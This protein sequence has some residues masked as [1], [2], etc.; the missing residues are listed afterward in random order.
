MNAP[1]NNPDANKPDNAPAAPAGFDPNNPPVTSLPLPDEAEESAEDALKDDVGI[2]AEQNELIEEANAKLRQDFANELQESGIETMNAKALAADPEK[3]A[4]NLIK[5]YGDYQKIKAQ[6]TAL[7]NERKSLLP[8]ATRVDAV[9]RRLKNATRNVQGKWQHIPSMDN[10]AEG[11]KCYAAPMTVGAVMG[12]A[13]VMYT[14]GKSR[15]NIQHLDRA[16]IH[17]V[18]EGLMAIEAGS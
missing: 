3:T 5:L 12:A 13:A 14:D 16:V 2:D 18:G 4:R 6:N 15:L 17:D 7:Q 10:P 1:T 8:K 9:E 11:I